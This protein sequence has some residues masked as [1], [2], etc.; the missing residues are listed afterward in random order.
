M[1]A[2]PIPEADLAETFCRS[3]GPGGQNVNKVNTAVHLR[4]IPTGLAVRA[5][6]SR[7]REQNRTEARRLL[8]ERL[9]EREREKTAAR[10][11]ER[12]K[13]R[14]RRSPRPRGLKEKILRHKKRRGDLKKLRGRATD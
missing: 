4:H 12:E 5:E 7:H 6:S 1:A 9:A 10:R 14:R 11:A 13:Q 8:A 2:R 3:S